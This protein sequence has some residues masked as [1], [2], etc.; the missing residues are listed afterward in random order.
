MGR[1]C[2][3]AAL[4][5]VTVLGTL[6]MGAA[7]FLL[8]D[9][10][11]RRVVCQPERSHQGG[12]SCVDGSAA[13]ARSLIAAAGA[14]CG[15]VCAAVWGCTFGAVVAAVMCFLLAA[16]ALVDARER[17]IP[18]AA[19]LSMV[20]VGVIAFGL[21]C[22]SVAGC[23]VAG[24]VLGA[25]PSARVGLL[26]RVIGIFAASVPLLLVAVPTGG[27]GGG[28]VKLMAGVGAALGW[29]AALSSLAVGVV[30]GGIYAT[31]LLVMRKIDLSGTFAFGPFLCA[32]A[33]LAM[34]C[35]GV[36]V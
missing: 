6:S 1:D 21:Q 4:D 32:G 15:V 28:D 12:G 11:L 27:F 31:V 36:F 35:Q 16:V 9:M 5:A 20:V 13:P 19:C 24:S 10:A 30:T 7:V 14:L 8:G 34:V 26:D 29:K 23:G 25:F 22:V 33:F 18:N 17:V 2:M 3:C